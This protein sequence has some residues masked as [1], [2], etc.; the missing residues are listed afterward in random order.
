L[1]K[2]T[3]LP[4]IDLGSK[5]LV[6]QEQRR[7]DLQKVENE[8]NG[9]HEAQAEGDL[10]RLEKLHVTCGD[11]AVLVGRVKYLFYVM[12]CDREFKLGF[13]PGQTVLDAKKKIVET[14]SV[15][16]VEDVTLL[17]A[18]KVLRDGF[19]LDRLRIGTQWVVVHIRDTMKLLLFSTQ[20]MR[21][22]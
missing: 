4:E 13:A 11:T 12:D 16:S 21:P 14:Y 15:D 19:V 10:G 7:V 20:V 6:V 9:V 18:G 5:F 22:M 2:T 8:G 17:F 1:A 3:R